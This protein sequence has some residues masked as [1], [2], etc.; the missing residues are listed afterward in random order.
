MKPGPYN[1]RLT[2]G[3]I[4]ISMDREEYLDDQNI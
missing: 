1:K 3:L 2:K 4:R